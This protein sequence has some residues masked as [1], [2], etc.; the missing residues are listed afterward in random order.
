MSYVTTTKELNKILKE[1]HL[2]LDD[3]K[4]KFQS[5]SDKREVEGFENYINVTY[6]VDLETKSIRGSENGQIFA[7][8]Y[9]EDDTE[10]FIAE[11]QQR[12]ISYNS[13][14][15]F[16]KLLPEDRK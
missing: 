9:N 2:K 12:F 16:N 6:F 11:K 4:R 7:M 13:L 8:L 10:E 14:N 3:K 1:N 5:S 15:K